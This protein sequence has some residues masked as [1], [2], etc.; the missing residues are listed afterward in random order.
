MVMVALVPYNK[1]EPQKPLTERLARS[2]E[3]AGGPTC[4]CRCLG[5]LHGIARF[6]V[7]GP[8]AAY[9]DLP[10]DDPHH[11]FTKAELEEMRRQ[12][13]EQKRKAWEEE[14]KRKWEFVA[15]LNR[16]TSPIPPHKR[17][18]PR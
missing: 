17:R 11:L 6:G 12:R 7:G 18:W 3:E 9:E 16:L 15:S 8:R 14:V 2:C 4:E 13:K 1:D 5:K 10:E